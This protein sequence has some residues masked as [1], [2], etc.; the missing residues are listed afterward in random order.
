[1]IT[2]GNKDI[3]EQWTQQAISDAKEEVEYE[4]TQRLVRLAEKELDHL[5]IKEAKEEAAKWK[6]LFHAAIGSSTDE[7]LETFKLK[8]EIVRLTKELQVTQ[9]QRDK[10]EKRLRKANDPPNSRKTRTIIT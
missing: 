7:Q 9:E 4:K 8:R 1:M 10:L 2:P 5:M 6:G 3:S